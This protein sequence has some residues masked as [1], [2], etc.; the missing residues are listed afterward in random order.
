MG[1]NGDIYKLTGYIAIHYN[2]TL[3]QQITYIIMHVV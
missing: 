3:F 1:L 2:Y